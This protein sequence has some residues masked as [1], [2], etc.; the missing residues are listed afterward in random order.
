MLK[1]Q[2]DVQLTYNTA[3][4]DTVNQTQTTTVLL[5]LRTTSGARSIAETRGITSVKVSN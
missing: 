1:L 2:T 5:F 3:T 4:G